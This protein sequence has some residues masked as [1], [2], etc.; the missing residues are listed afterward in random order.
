MCSMIVCAFFAACNDDLSSVGMGIQPED[1]VINVRTDTI[2][3]MSSTQ[4]IDSIYLKT[5]AGCLGNF[6]DLT[7][8]NINCGYMCNFYTASDSVFP[9]AVIGNKIDSVFLK[10]IYPSFLHTTDPCWYG[11]SL[12]TMEATV[13]GITVGKTLNKNFYSNVDPWN[14]TT[15]DSVWAKK[16]YTARNMNI[17]DSVYFTSYVP[18][19]KFKLPNSVGQRIYN[20]WN[21]PERKTIFGNLNNFFDFFPGV[22]ITSTYGSGNVINVAQTQLEVYF[23]MDIQRNTTGAID[24]TVS[25]YALFVASEEVTQLNKFKNK[26]EDDD[27]LTQDQDVSQTYLKTPAGVVTQLEISLK[28]I[29]D[30]I[31]DDKTFN[32]VQLS[33]SAMEQPSWEY[34]LS[35]PPKVLLIH[36][37]SV[38]PFFEESRVA[39]NSYSY[40]ASLSSTLKY[41]F[42]NI[43]AL[44]R[45]SI[46]KLKEQDIPKSEWPLL[47]LWVIPVSTPSFDGYNI[48]ITTNY[49]HPSGAMLKTGRENLKL[50]ITTTRSN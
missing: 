29:V 32:G 22:Y 14:Y 37:D 9:Y 1:D 36:P 13:Y 43:A 30:K 46:S 6:D 20:A 4:I 15:P 18:N 7:Y 34:A 23:S 8:G 47:K 35:M 5:I 42:G 26:K 25:R 24:S 49:F 44:I 39:N 16:S 45:N 2:S 31:G 27:R 40:Y 3:F 19:I 21:S 50:Y 11:D 28:E 38:K 17:P 33:L 10:V 41:D 12:T 48:S